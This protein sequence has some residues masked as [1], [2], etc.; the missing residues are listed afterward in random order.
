MGLTGGF[1]DDLAPDGVRAALERA[2]E[3]VQ[4]ASPQ[5]VA[6]IAATGQLSE[7]QR[8]EI[9]HVFRQLTARAAR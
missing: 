4:R 8:A 5:A 1:L 6:D 7:D 9:G 3:A 2:R